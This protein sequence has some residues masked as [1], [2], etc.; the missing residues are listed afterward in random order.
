MLA[1]CACLLSLLVGICTRAMLAHSLL[2]LSF[3]G[4]VLVE[5]TVGEVLPAIEKNL[6]GVRHV[7]SCPTP[8][9]LSCPCHPSPQRS[10]S[11]CCSQ[12][13]G[14]IATYTGERARC[15]VTECFVALTLN[16]RVIPEQMKTKEKEADDF[17]VK[18][19]IRMASEDVRQ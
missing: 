15:V 1:C 14:L 18:Y 4:G 2:L 7:M 16:C 5:R 12:L 8:H 9:T 13:A 6:E 11:L 17:R 10:H 3:A 19:N